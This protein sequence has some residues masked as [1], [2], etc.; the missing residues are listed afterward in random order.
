MAVV[1][2]IVLSTGEQIGKDRFR[3]VRPAR[4]AMLF[5]RGGVKRTQD[6]SAGTAKPPWQGSQANHRHCRSLPRHQ[7]PEAHHNRAGRNARLVA[8]PPPYCFKMA[9]GAESSARW[10]EKNFLPAVCFT[11]TRQIYLSGLLWGNLH[12]SRIKFY[13]GLASSVV[14]PGQF[15]GKT[16]ADDSHQPWVAA[17]AYFSP[18]A[19]SGPRTRGHESKQGESG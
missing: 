13:Y 5:A 17:P 4:A 8:R 16:V 9:D 12:H 7:R 19:E 11:L 14:L 18:L 2:E 15:P 6:F 1:P 10:G 3:R